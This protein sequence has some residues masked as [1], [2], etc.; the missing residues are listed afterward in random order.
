MESQTLSDASPSS[1][2]NLANV[3]S[4]TYPPYQSSFSLLSFASGALLALWLAVPNKIRVRVYKTLRSLGKSLYGS[5]NG[6][7]TVQRLPF[8]LYLKYQGEDECYR[9]E[10]NALR[11][12]RNH[13]SVPVP[14]PLDVVAGHQED[15]DDLF[16]APQGYFL[17]TKIP[18]M[19]MST[20]LPILS[21]EDCEHIA[22]Q[23]K[24]YVA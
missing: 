23:L 2:N 5:P 10:F 1:P 6:Y 17:M 18:G 4:S 19:P 20:C 7:S 12:V 21:D 9:N 16:S 3:K 11:L 24:D 8:G 14:K 22:N 15:P 13:T